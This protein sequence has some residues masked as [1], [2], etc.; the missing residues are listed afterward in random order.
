M[1][2]APP[3]RPQLNAIRV[4]S[5]DHAGALSPACVP[6]NSVTPLPSGAIVY[7]SRA[8]LT[9]DA[10]AIAPVIAPSGLVGASATD[11]GPSTTAGPSTPAGPS[12][13]RGASAPS[14]SP[15]PPHPTP[16]TKQITHGR[17]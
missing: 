13:D 1:S 15:P 3:T 5:A 12:I 2:A 10:N 7:S 4:P 9:S 11:G 8:P 16:T 14:P 17:I 6:G